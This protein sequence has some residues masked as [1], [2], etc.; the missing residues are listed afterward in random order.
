MEL[1]LRPGQQAMWELGEEINVEDHYDF[2]RQMRRTEGIDLRLMGKKILWIVNK[3]TVKTYRSKTLLKRIEEEMCLR[4]G[5]KLTAGVVN[6][7]CRGDGAEMMDAPLGWKTLR[8]VNHSCY[9]K[10]IGPFKKEAECEKAMQETVDDAYRR[11][12]RL[13]G[14]SF[15]QIRHGARTE[16][17]LAQDVK[18]DS[19]LKQ[20]YYIYCAAMHAREHVCDPLPQHYYETDEHLYEVVRENAPRRHYFDVEWLSSD[21]DDIS[22]YETLLDAF[23]EFMEGHESKLNYV[24][25]TKGSRWKNDKTYKHSYHVIYRDLVLKDKDE[26]ALFMN[27]FKGFLSTSTYAE[28]LAELADYKLV[29]KR[30]YVYKYDGAVYTKNRLMRLP[31][32]CKPGGTVPLMT[33]RE[34]SSILTPITISLNISKKDCLKVKP[35]DEEERKLMKSEP[36]GLAPVH[37]A[38]KTEVLDVLREKMNITRKMVRTPSEGELCMNMTVASEDQELM[39]IEDDDFPKYSKW[40][41]INLVEIRKEDF[42]KYLTVLG[43][44]VEVF[45]VD[46][47]TMIE[48]MGHSKAEKGRIIYRYVVSTNKGRSLGGFH[49]KLMMKYGLVSENRV[50]DLLEK[51]MTSAVEDIP[52]LISKENSFGIRPEFTERKELCDETSVEIVTGDMGIGKTEKIMDSIESCPDGCTVLYIIGRVRLADELVTRLNKRASINATRLHTGEPVP[53]KKN[54]YVAVINSLEKY[55]ELTPYFVVIDEQETTFSN[56]KMGTVDNEAVQELLMKFVKG[57]NLAKFCDAMMTMPSI[58]FAQAMARYVLEDDHCLQ[59]T[60]LIREGVETKQ[61]VICPLFNDIVSINLYNEKLTCYRPLAGNNG[62]IIRILHEVSRNHKIAIAVPTLQWADT[63]ERLIP[64]EKKV[65][66]I[67]GRTKKRKFQDLKATDVLIYTSAISAG[68]SIDIKNHFHCVFVVINAPVCGSDGRVVWKTPNLGEMSQMAGRVRY[69][70]TPN[71]F[72]TIDGGFARKVGLVP[73]IP[74]YSVAQDEPFDLLTSGEFFLTGKLGVLTKEEFAI[75]VQRWFSKIAFPGSPIRNELLAEP[76]VISTITDNLG[77]LNHNL[78]Q[79]NILKFCNSNHDYW[80]LFEE[81]KRGKWQRKKLTYEE[82]MEF[83][84]EGLKFIPCAN[85]EYVVALPTNL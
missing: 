71:V 78:D 20:Y 73:K 35:L 12:V 6:R 84:E 45:K 75:F 33:D 43:A 39:E 31:N 57:S 67:D 13:H 58:I 60:K 61:R 63:L 80:A 29:T 18:K 46:E 59:F 26:H 47:E 48:H 56:L 69:P 64:K 74:K 16:I 10:K 37:L 11:G 62:F 21:P 66:R 49:W 7:L 8:E 22:P 83:E 51:C 19:A 79:C 68:H 34:K 55:R 81:K 25:V 41:D 28:T 23:R 72:V 24:Y 9:W 42:T 4:I 14:E 27:R 54:V 38:H 85:R 17:R 44:I 15:A 1:K 32:Q 3:D 82:I 30:I 52:R 50:K 65:T 77:K 2:A 36:Y 40:Q 70:K 5:K 76:Y 53:D